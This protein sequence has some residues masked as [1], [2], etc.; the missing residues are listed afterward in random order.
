MAFVFTVDLA[1][2]IPTTWVFRE[3][4]HRALLAFVGVD[5]DCALTYAVMIGLA[6]GAGCTEYYFKLIEVDAENNEERE[7]W[8]SREVG[9][10]MDE[11]NRELILRVILIVTSIL[12]TQERPDCFYCCTHGDNMPPHALEKHEALNQVF[13]D[14]GYQVT[15]TNSDRGRHSWWVERVE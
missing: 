11:D 3:A 5:D 4:G 8:D 1:Q 13:T 10:F 14:C 9:E 12:V 15:L 2:P 6:A 7:Y